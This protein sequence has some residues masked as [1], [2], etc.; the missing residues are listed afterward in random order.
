MEF[1]TY[2]LIFLIC[3]LSLAIVNNTLKI[4]LGSEDFF[5]SEFSM[6]DYLA[7]GRLA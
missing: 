3:F 5:E 7:S 4:V 1:V 2:M 6:D